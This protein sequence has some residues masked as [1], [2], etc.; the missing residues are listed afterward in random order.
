MATFYCDTCLNEKTSKA[1]ECEELICEH[2][3]K[4]HQSRTPHH[5]VNVDI[6]PTSVLTSNQYCEIHTERI[7]DL[8]CTQDDM[9][10]C[11]SCMPEKHR[12]CYSVIKLEDASRNIDDSS[13]LIATKSELNG[14]ANTIGN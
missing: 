3:V 7:L 9:L 13:M 4:V 2:C 5:L 6:L 12:N 11:R 10:I 8:F 1:I 14:I